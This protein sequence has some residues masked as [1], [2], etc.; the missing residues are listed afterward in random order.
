MPPDGGSVVEVVERMDSTVDVTQGIYDT[1]LVEDG[2][3]IDIEAHLARLD[4]SVRSIFGSTIRA[5]LDEA[6]LRRAAGLTGRQRLRI[7]AVPRDGEVRVTMTARTIDDDASTW[8][9]VPRTIAGG[10]GEHKWS[11]RRAL[12][13]EGAPDRDLLLVADDG[14]YAG[15]TYLKTMPTLLFNKLFVHVNMPVDEIVNKSNAFPQAEFICGYASGIYQMA[16]LQ[17]AHKI[18]HHPCF[19]AVSYTHLTMPTIYSV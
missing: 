15:V 2:A 16:K 1:L 7:D 3:V 17:L 14:N 12:E 5:G 6:V 10:F 18:N 11:D 13:H 8:A 4:A 19:V 9:L